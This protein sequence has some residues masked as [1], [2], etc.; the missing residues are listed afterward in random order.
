MLVEGFAL[1]LCG[2]IEYY[3]YFLRLLWV[4]HPVMWD[5]PCPTVLSRLLLHRHL[6]SITVLDHVRHEC[7]IVALVLLVFTKF[8]LQLL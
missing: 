3:T 8:E 5:V 2:A 4:V 7:C 1:K 6:L